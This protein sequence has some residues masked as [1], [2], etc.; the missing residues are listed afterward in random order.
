MDAR[1][2]S[3]LRRA[4]KAMAKATGQSHFF[5]KKKRS[6]RY[7]VPPM[8]TAVAASRSTNSPNDSV[9]PMATAVSAARSTNS[10]N[11]NV[12]QAILEHVDGRIAAPPEYKKILTQVVKA[13]NRNLSDKEIEAIVKVKYDEYFNNIKS[14]LSEERKKKGKP[15]PVGSPT[16]LT[17]AV[18][19]FPVSPARYA[20]LVPRESP[21]GRGL[22]LTMRDLPRGLNEGNKAISIGGRRRTRRNKKY[23]KK[24]KKHH[25]K[26]SYKKHAKKHHKKTHKK[27]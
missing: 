9:L 21:T 16:E 7:S 4:R 14:H 19:A 1:N 23:N 22:P 18:Q 8:A 10:P 24:S 2:T 11:E 5:S 20:P 12:P 27:H 15:S 17:S 26:R 25:K 3:S 6:P 13:A